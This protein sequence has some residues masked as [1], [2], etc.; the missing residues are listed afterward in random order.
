MHKIILKRKDILV[1]VLML[2]AGFVFVA[3]PIFAVEETGAKKLELTNPLCYKV[4]P[5]ATCTLQ[6]IIGRAIKAILG[7][8][9]SIALVMFIW[10]GF[11]MLT[12][13]GSPDQVK[14]GKETLLWATI[15]LL[16]IFLSYA[17][18]KAVF[19]ALGVK[20]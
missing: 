17:L 18:V 3:Q 8:I 2:L 14:K 9:G 16:V 13:G 1:I 15:G 10:G 6:L 19:E 20:S 7:I 12:A 11:Q 4:E 5:P